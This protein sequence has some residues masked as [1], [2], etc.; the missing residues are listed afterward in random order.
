MRPGPPTPA[1]PDRQVIL[2]IRPAAFEGVVVADESGETDPRRRA[3][4]VLVGLAVAAVLVVV[5]M[6]KLFDSS[7]GGHDSSGAAPDDTLSAPPS[8]S[9]RP[10]ASSARRPSAPVTPT[11][12]R[13][14]T[15][16][17]GP[18][19]ASCPTDSPCVLQGDAA[20]AIQAVDTYRTQHGR[21]SVPGTVSKAAQACALSDGSDCSGGWAETY[22]N[23]LDGTAAVAKIAKLGKLLDPQLQ[24]FEVGWAY[25]PRTKTYYLAVIRTD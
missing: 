12:D 22:L 24:S 4:V 11:S 19:T 17:T 23:Q 21:T 9:S 3:A 6:I 8:S 16:A 18:A 13:T 5:V 25:R 10:A 15:G 14:A 2:D 7:G 20:H 1:T